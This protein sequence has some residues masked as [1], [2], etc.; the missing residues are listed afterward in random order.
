MCR[1]TSQGSRLDLRLL[2][3]IS[4]I[5]LL[6]LISREYKQ[7]SQIRMQYL[8]VWLQSSVVDTEEELNKLS[9]NLRNLLSTEQR[10]QATNLLLKL[11]QTITTSNS[12]KLGSLMTTCNK[13]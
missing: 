13:K 3:L 9:L 6:A 11:N 10:L 1:G 8:Q 7:P 2:N 12:N 5:L 4:I